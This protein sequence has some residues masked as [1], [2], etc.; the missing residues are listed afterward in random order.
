[1]HNF[2]LEDLIAYYYNEVS[3]AKKEAIKEALLSDSQLQAN[4]N[5]LLSVIDCLHP[6]HSTPSKQSLGNLTTYARKLME[7]LH[8][9]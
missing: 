3:V 5:E 1:M 9:H 7:E 2:T 8:T 6:I 4:Y